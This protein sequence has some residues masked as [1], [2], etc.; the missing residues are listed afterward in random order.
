MNLSFNNQRRDTNFR[1]PH[2]HIF[3]SSKEKKKMK[4]FTL[5]EIARHNKDNDNYIVIDDKV[6]DVTTFS[7]FHPVR[8]DVRR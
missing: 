1:I 7:R 3:N 6:Y 8:R 4:T 2:T 5:A